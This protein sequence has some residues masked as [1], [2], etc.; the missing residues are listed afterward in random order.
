MKQWRLK[1]LVDGFADITE[2]LS[3]DAIVETKED[4]EAQKPK[5][6]DKN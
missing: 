2:D 5:K 1:I 3:E 4:K 6:E